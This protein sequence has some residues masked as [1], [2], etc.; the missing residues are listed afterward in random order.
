MALTSVV[1]L[2]VKFSGVVAVALVPLLLGLRAI[3]PWPWPILRYTASNRFV[4]LIVSAIVTLL[5]AGISYAGIWAVYGFRFQPT[6]EAGV[7]LNMTELSQKVLKNEKTVQEYH[8]SPAPKPGDIQLTLPARAALFANN[9]HLFPQA[10]LAGFLFTYSNAMVR[11]AYLCGHI[12]PVGWWWYFPFAI[13]VKTPIATLLATAVAAWLAIRALRQGRFAEPGRQWS[14][15]CLAIPVAVFLASAM[16]SSLNI[17]LRHVLAIYPFAF[18]AIGC[19]AASVWRTAQRNA[20]ITI[21][22]LGL[23][24]A[25]ESLSVFPDYIPYF[26]VIAANAPGG[27]LALLGDSNLDWGQDLLLLVDWQKQHP[28][29]KLYLCYFG[30]ADPTYYGLKYISLPGGYYYDTH[31]QWVDPSTPSVVAISASNLQGILL[32]DEL[33]KYY[34]QWR[35]RKPIAVLGGSIYLYENDPLKNLVGRE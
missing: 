20:K 31:R 34:A 25:I 15:L 14:A 22:G 23:L 29:E 10:F 16:A 11:L 2:T 17:G 21:I 33:G 12:S 18:V 24:L 28:D 9:H 30:Y 13:L 3:L 1:T 7:Y 8:G 5:I 4:R 32:E 19:V 26:N 6:P 35:N 27:K